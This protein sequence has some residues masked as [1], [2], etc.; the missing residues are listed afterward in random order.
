MTDRGPQDD[1]RSS[2]SA[3]MKVVVTPPG[4]APL[5]AYAGEIQAIDEHGVRITLVDWFSGAFSGSDLFIPW[6]NL[7]A[8]LVYTEDHDLRMFADDAGGWQNAM[9][10]PTTEPVKKAAK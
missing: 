10:H 4:V 7:Q 5:V 9:N 8:A 6:R 3:G 1:R 2:L